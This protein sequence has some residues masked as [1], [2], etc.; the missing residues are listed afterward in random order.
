MQAPA[1][2]ETA[3]EISEPTVTE[4]EISTT[5]VPAIDAPS[6]EPLSDHANLAHLEE[7][8]ERPKSPWTPSYSVTTLPGSGP[9]PHVE[10]DVDETPAAEVEAE[11][12][13][14]KVEGTETPKIVTP[15]D[16][17][18][19]EPVDPTAITE[20]P[21]WTQSYSVTSQPGSPR[22]S[23]KV[24][25][26]ELEPELQPLD[27]VQEPPLVAPIVELADVPET[28]VTPAAED[29]DVPEPVPEEESKP[30]WTQSYSVTSQPGSPR[31]S[32]KQVSEEVP[33]EEEE[34]KPSWTQSY[35]V[36]SQPGS[37]R[38]SPKE[39]LQE[40]IVE[41]LAVADEPTTVVTP[42]VEEAATAPD[43]TETAERPKSP[44]TPSYSVTTLEGQT[45][46]APPDDAEPEPEVVTIPKSFNE[47]VS[48]VIHAPH[49]GALPSE[50][51][52][53]DDGRPERPKSPW[54][55]S[56]S[57]TTLPG[58]APAEEPEPD[59][60]TGEPSV[61]VEA[62]V[63]ETVKPVEDQPKENGTTTDVFEVHEAVSQ[64]AVHEEAEADVQTSEPA[65]PQL[66][67]VSFPCVF[68]ISRSILK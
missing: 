17:K 55:P 32:P 36:T 66:D 41:P 62:S 52:A 60:V 40:P 44:W 23:P 2:T 67:L 38:V 19:E 48:E 59:S 20:S 42:P 30:A 5:D 50:P 27:S 25:L 47:E 29:E 51:L 63:P 16:E 45:E 15:E 43:E 4:D 12:S 57:V 64:L 68:E 33:E 53:V 31:V 61:D 37:P 54:T 39:D 26:K 56:Y 35:S 1:E 65:H 9:S 6:E 58:S 10:S 24:E 3:V 28:V 49:T 22:V 34:V 46:R 7:E 11:T 13:P 8:T 14:A 18:D 21:S